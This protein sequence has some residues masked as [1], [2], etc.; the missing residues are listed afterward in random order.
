MY[1]NLILYTALHCSEGESSEIPVLRMA[2][3]HS[4]N[5]GREYCRVPVSQPVQ[6]E[7]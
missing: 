7:A 2:N 6:Q 5:L 4:G 1:H 3:V